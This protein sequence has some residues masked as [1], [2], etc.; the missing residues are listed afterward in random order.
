MLNEML[1]D[2]VAVY[3]RTGIETRPNEIVPEPME[4]AGMSW[5]PPKEFGSEGGTGSHE[6]QRIAMG[7]RRALS[8]VFGG[9]DRALHRGPRERIAPAARAFDR[10]G[11]RGFADACEPFLGRGM[12]RQK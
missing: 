7:A 10:R 6:G 1:I 12:R 11:L 2:E 9:A 5:V 3:M 4:C 8:S